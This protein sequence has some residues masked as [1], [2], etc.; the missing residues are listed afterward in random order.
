MT[1]LNTY[2]L[3]NGATLRNRF[4]M[5]PMTTYAGEASGN[6]SSDELTYYRE[7][8]HGVG[9]LI[10][11]CAYVA[12]S[13]Q[14]FQGQI[15]A[16]DDA[17][18]PSLRSIAE[19]I[20]QGGA[21]AVLQIHHGGRQARQA[22]V[23]NGDIISA[24]DVAGSHGE[25]AR[26]ATTDE[27][28]ALVDAYAQATRRAIE[29]GFDGIEIHGANTYLIQQFF[30]GFTNKRTDKY[31]GS[32]EKRL[33]FPLAVANA[34]LAVKEKHAAADFIVGYRFSPEEPEEDG[35]TMDD[36]A[37]LLAHLQQ[38]PLDY[39]HIS[40]GDYRS[41]T[42]R[43]TK[44]EQNRIT[45]V[46]ELVR[47]DLPLIGVGS[48]YEAHEA[49]EAA[50]LGADLIAIGRALLIEPHWVEK[51]AQGEQVATKM[52]AS[53]PP[54]IPPKMFAMLESRTGWIPGL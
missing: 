50:A 38:L 31:G 42:H 34:V 13:G 45:A 43:Y 30:S 25:L 7:R 24:G 4:V 47:D 52:D 12:A 22:L 5:A 10:T 14:A 49:E 2:T 6:V 11:A 16:H 26:A 39:V 8:A 15:S 1:L 48:I 3:P 33:T 41:T 46:R 37:V 35:I 29:A 44:G 32:L 27:V 19:T 53:N 51:V 54:V 40:L 18:I 9:M 20:Q 23:P 28:D 36:T 17:F 21:K